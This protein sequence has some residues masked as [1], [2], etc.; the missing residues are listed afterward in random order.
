M[1]VDLMLQNEIRHL[2]LFS[3]SDNVLRAFA[4]SGISITITLPNESL[5]DIKYPLMAS[6]WLQQRVRK[7]RNQNVDIR[8]LFVGSEPFSTYTRKNTYELAPIALRLIQDSIIAN[9]YDNLIAT[10]PHFTDVLTPNLMKPSEADFREDLKE[11]MVEIIHLLN[12]T[13]APFVCNIFPIYYVMNHTDDGWDPEFAFINNK[14]NFTVEDNGLVYRNVFEFL[15]DSFLHAIA[16][17]G[18]PGMELMVGKIG[19]PTDGY[20]NANVANAERFFKE[21]LPYIRSNKGTPLRPG[22]SIDVSIHSLADENKNYINMAP[23]QRHWGVY[24]SDGQ[25][26]YKID[27][28][29]QGR[30]IFP[31]TAKGL[32]HMPRR[33]C[34]FNGDSSDIDKVRLQLGEAC[35]LADCTTLSL[36]GSCSHLELRQNVSYAFNMA[37]QANAQADIKGATCDFDGL[38]VLV[39]EDPSNGTC[40]FP[41]EILAAEK[42]DRDGLT[43][44]GVERSDLSR[45]SFFITLITFVF[46][47][48]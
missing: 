18:S 24:W 23:F 43:D 10:I 36:G 7:Y 42:A 22:A 16:K 3:P 6:Y 25:P 8:Y 26:K 38:G 35:K 28:T 12:R 47:L 14:S 13:N 17:A 46:I 30:D 9:G 21:F 20:V 1:V 5:K 29:G 4:S 32:I 33:W 11:R 19:W 27:F 15:Y 2:T 31:T 39:P 48:G 37:F 34:I 45:F 40:K 44:S 41:V